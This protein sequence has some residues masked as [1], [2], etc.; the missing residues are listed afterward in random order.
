MQKLRGHAYQGAERGERKTKRPS[1]KHIIG[2]RIPPNVPG[3]VPV[4]ANKRELAR[5]AAIMNGRRT[6]VANTPRHV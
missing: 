5:F 3:V 4:L 6:N 1:R 2:Q